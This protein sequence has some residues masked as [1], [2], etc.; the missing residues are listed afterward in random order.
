MLTFLQRLLCRD[1]SGVYSVEFALLAV[2]FFGLLMAYGELSYIDFAN[3]VLIDSLEKATRATQTGVVTAAKVTNTA[4]P[5]VTTTVDFTQA[6]NFIQY[7]LCPSAGN[8]PSTLPGMTPSLFPYFFDCNNL[9]RV[10]IRPA[11]NFL[12]T[13]VGISDIV[14]LSQGSLKY[15]LAEPNTILVIRA[16]YY[17]PAILPL[18]IYGPTAGTTTQTGGASG[19]YY[20]VIYS[21]SAIKT[22]GFT[23]VS[24]G[25]AC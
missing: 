2:P 3:Q 17:L 9:L 16:L 14:G 12:G 8:Q 23:N 15:C 18:D 13:T 22:E 21:T 20:H 1:D 10:D 11:T 24:S 5:P 6:S 19:T 4:T 7:A 25:V